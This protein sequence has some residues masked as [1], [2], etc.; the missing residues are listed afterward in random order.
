MAKKKVTK[1]VVKTTNEDALIDITN[2]LQDGIAVY[3]DELYSLGDKMSEE[4]RN[5]NG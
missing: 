2:R 1:K 5:V 3:I 4:G